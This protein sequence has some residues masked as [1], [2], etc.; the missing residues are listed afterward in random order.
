LRCWHENADGILELEGEVLFLLAVLVEHLHAAIAGDAVA[1][2]NDEIAFGQ[3][4]EAVNRPRFQAPARQHLTRLL[5]MEQLLSAQHDEPRVDESER[6]S[7]PSRDKPEPVG[8]GELPGGEHLAEALALGLIETGNQHAVTGLNVIQ[9]I[10]NAGHLAAESFHRLD[11]Q[12][13]GRLNGRRRHPRQTHAWKPDEL[14]Q[15]PLAGEQAAR[16]GD[17][18]EIVLG[19]FEEAIQ[20]D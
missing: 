4:E 13:T 3:L 16:V 20:L 18:F 9:L 2:V 12:M 6:R 5:A 19:W 17:A 1:N 10:A 7:H 11:A 8:L 15:G 14:L